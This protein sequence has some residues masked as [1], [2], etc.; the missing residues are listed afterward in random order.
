MPRLTSVPMHRAS[1][2]R[3]LFAQERRQDPG[4][5]TFI[6]SLQRYPALSSHEARHLALKAQTG[7][8]AARDRLVECHLR[9]VVSIA[10]PYLGRG[11]PLM[12]LIQEGTLGL[13]AAVTKYDPDQQRFSTYASWWVLDSVHKAVLAHSNTIRIPNHVQEQAAR[14]HTAEQDAA[15]QGTSLSDDELSTLTGVSPAHIRRARD[16]YRMRPLSLDAERPDGLTLAEMLSLD[17]NTSDQASYSPSLYAQAVEDAR[18]ETLYQHL[19]TVLDRTEREIIYQ[20]Y[21]LQHAY[22]EHAFEEI[23]ADLGLSR[24]QVRAQHDA[25]LVKLRVAYGLNT[26]DGSTPVRDVADTSDSTLMAA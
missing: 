22:R 3:A 5:D 12:D 4:L 20:R 2:H 15:A 11:I 26:A 8:T 6:T 7:D 10:L 17:G 16:A 21:G 25:A 1:K 24:R 9:L 23:A 13:L 18:I 19:R 14:I